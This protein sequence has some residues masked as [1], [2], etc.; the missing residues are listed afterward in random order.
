MTEPELDWKKLMRDASEYTAQESETGE[1]IDELFSEPHKNTGDYP[2]PLEL[3][4]Q[5]N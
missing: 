2:P 3:P 4:E 1:Y 5:D